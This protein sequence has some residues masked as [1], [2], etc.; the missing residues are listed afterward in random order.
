M[1]KQT[2]LRKM[3][4]TKFNTQIIKID[5]SICDSH[6][7]EN[8]MRSLLMW[9]KIKSDPIFFFSYAKKLV[10]VSICILNTTNNYWLMKGLTYVPYY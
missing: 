2:K 9:L 8:S 6:V 5:K 4:S 10:Y 3:S 7:K 1:R